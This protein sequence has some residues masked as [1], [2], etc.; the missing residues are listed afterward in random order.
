MT[1]T[2]RPAGP[3]RRGPDGGRTREFTVCV[4]GRAVGG[5][6]LAAEPD[7]GPGRVEA[8]AIDP[9]DRRRGRGTVAALAAEEVLRQWGCREVLVSVPAADPE[10]AGDG[11]GTSEAAYGLRT[12]LSLGYAEANRTLHKDLAPGGAAPAVE[13]PPGARLR[14]PAVADAEEW[15][16][17]QRAG[18]VAAA[19][20]TGVPAAR[21][22]AHA[23]AS[24]AAALPY[25]TLLALDVGGVTAGRIWL[26]VTPPSGWVHAVEV[27][28]AHRG[29]GFGRSLMLAAEAR[30]R[31][32][33][34]TG[35]GLNVF[36]SNTVALGLYESL[37]YGVRLRQLWKSLL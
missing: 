37:G 30:C 9:P 15:L 2:L 23:A 17:R 21:A 6:R 14:E 20:A 10:A 7:G 19:R 34:L 1:T 31:A 24:F 16:A 28:H 3:A 13:L 8:L 32:A 29:Q 26:A 25:S 33:G 18:F 12:A 11:P 22:E 36:T 4:N 5:L 35:L 27:D